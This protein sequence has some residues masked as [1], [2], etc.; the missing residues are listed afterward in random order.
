MLYLL[1]NLNYLF[2]YWFK[3]P[4]SI[5]ENTEFFLIAG[6]GLDKKESVIRIKYRKEF[7]QEVLT[8]VRA[9]EREYSFP[10]FEEFSTRFEQEEAKVRRAEVEEVKRIVKTN[11]AIMQ[12]AFKIK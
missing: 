1:I 5:W 3:I 9:I 11:K 8:T 6:K 10:D 2:H 4:G 7:F 12:D